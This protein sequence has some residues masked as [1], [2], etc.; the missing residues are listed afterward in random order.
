M[1]LEIF[2]KMNL[3]L[4]ATANTDCCTQTLVQKLY[5]VCLY[6]ASFKRMKTLSCERKKHHIRVR[7]N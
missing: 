4:N 7:T 3:F 6:L 2:R 5:F 1:F